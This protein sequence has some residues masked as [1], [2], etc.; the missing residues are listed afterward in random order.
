MDYCGGNDDDEKK[1]DDFFFSL[2]IFDYSG[3]T[4]RSLIISR[5]KF[6]TE[7]VSLVSQEP[8]DFLPQCVRVCVRVHM[9]V[10]YG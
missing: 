2:F 3:K 8:F 1:N 9:C 7:T 10:I 4:N 6:R 5:F